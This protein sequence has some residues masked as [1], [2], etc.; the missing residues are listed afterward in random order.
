M[1][2]NSYE[3][4]FLFLPIVYLGWITILNGFGKSASFTFLVIASFFYYGYWKPEYLL[5]MIVSILINFFIGELLGHKSRN[6]V[7]KRNVL[8]AG[9]VLNLSLLAYYKYFNFFITNANSLFDLSIGVETIFLPLAISFFTFQQIAYL[10]DAYQGKTSEYNFNHYL[11]FISFFPQLIAGPIVHHSEMM[12]QFNRQ[13]KAKIFDD[14]FFK[15]LSWFSI[16]LFKKVVIA[17]TI[18][19]YATPVFVLAD[20]GQG[21]DV[22]DA[23]VGVLAY[24]LQLYFDFSG[25]SDMAIGLA[26]MFGIMLPLNFD[27]PYKSKSIIEFWRRWHMTLSRFLRDYLYIPLG[28]N[29]KGKVRRYINLSLTML[30]GGLWHGASWNFV[31]WGALHASYLVLNNVWRK[32]FDHKL[33]AKSKVYIVLSTTLTFLAV[34][35]AWVVFRAET[36]DGA[37]RIYSGMLGNVEL[38]NVAIGEV[39]SNIIEYERAITSIVIGLIL[40]FFAPNTRKIVAYIWDEM[41]SLGAV[42][43]F[44]SAAYISVLLV[45]S[46]TLMNRVSEFLYFQF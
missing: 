44:L 2:F 28:G 34:I 41:E 1:L 29:K 11:L 36:F 12:P 8:I 20:S 45:I 13:S 32:L 18:A 33:L 22:V 30:L 17:D 37:L 7:V 19:L 24:S 25:Y 4:I 23:W 35:L 16:G 43:T 5:L 46:L 26:L 39:K 40:V 10:V 9:I 15:G 27:S 21:I 38:F 42:K 6:K 3:F 31:L 14:N